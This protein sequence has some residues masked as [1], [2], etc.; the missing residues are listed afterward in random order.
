MRMIEE[1]SADSGEEDWAPTLP[2]M[3]TPSSPQLGWL[4]AYVEGGSLA[5]VAREFD[6]P[7]YELQKLSRTQWWQEELNA[8]LREKAAVE[9]AG[10]TRILGKTLEAMEDRLDNGDVVIANGVARRIPVKAADLTKM[11]NGVFTQR[12]LLQG[13]PTHIEATQDKLQELA[14]KLRMLGAKDVSLEALP[15]AEN[16]PEAE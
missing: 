16:G 13:M 9:L 1:G 2:G 15:E 12:Q 10:M 5:R 11:A 6:V 14:D 8:L 3:P 4:W 7:L